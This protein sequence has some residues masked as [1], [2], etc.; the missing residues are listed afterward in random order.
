MPVG[1][2]DAG[3]TP[4]ESALLELHEEIGTDKAEILAKSR[5]WLR[6]DLPSP[7]VGKVWQGRYRG[8]EQCWFALRFLGEDGD[9][10]VATAHPEFD[11]WRW[12]ELDEVPALVIPRS[13]EHTSELQ[14][15]MRISYAVFCLKKK[16]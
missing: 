14:S 11:A 3:E 2:I 8:Q 15:L 13:E 1:G 6:Y 9:I 5:H 12:V 4:E 7:L 16:K 10:D